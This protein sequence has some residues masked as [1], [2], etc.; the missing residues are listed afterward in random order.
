[1]HI[2]RRSFTASLALTLALPARLRA[3]P[4]DLLS[5][6]DLR[7]DAQELYK[8]L[9]HA[10]FDL[11][12]HRPRSEYDREYAHLVAGITRPLDRA[13]AT[14]MF[15]RFTAFGRV[16]H[17]RIDA[18][19]TAYTAYLDGGG[20]VFP[21]SLRVIAGRAYVAYNASSLGEVRIGDEVLRI[22]D[23][24]AMELIDRLWRE[25]S[26]DT[27][28]MFHSILE[29]DLRRLLWMAQ[30]PL[31]EFPLCLRR[32]EGTPF[33]VRIPARTPAQ[34]DAVP[35]PPALNLA[36]KDR[37]YRMIGPDLAYLRPGPFYNA[38]NPNAL[39]DNRAFVALIDQAFE[40]FL[41]AGARTLMID[42]R[43]NPGG[44]NS[45]SDPMVA[46]FAS[47]PFR[48][49]SAFRIKVSEEA[50]ASNAAR[51]ANAD[52]DPTGT[53]ARLAR[54]YET[55]QIGDVIDFPIP[56]ISPRPGR[57]FAGQVHVLVNRHSYSNAVSVSA[58]VQD[59]G[60]GVVIGEETSDLAT[61]YGAMESFTLGRS[62]LEVGFP[63]AH[64]VRPSGNR[65]MRGVVP[66][67]AIPT[68]IMEPPD[69]PVLQ[70]A[71]ALA[72]VRAPG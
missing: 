19:R 31:P 42:L 29:W 53:S 21:L 34:M 41:N 51:L 72:T 26:A 60:F 57:R 13:A 59:L 65:S 47:Q 66:D 30:G 43:D 45:F 37:S 3:F 49:A 2:S 58:L 33:T 46:W 38:E 1:M 8:R 70:R 17:A 56:T 64:I 40:S 52:N 14:Q 39:F 7:A 25:V 44:D 67:I 5:P 28:Y 36:R 20:R 69:D 18:V 55:A 24:P 27:R 48:F 4:S 54:A 32:D 68:P 11:F 12:A 71:I 15:Q 63:K 10:H 61:T 35:R 22:C 9:Q 23:Q 16:A 50:I 62:R 6:D